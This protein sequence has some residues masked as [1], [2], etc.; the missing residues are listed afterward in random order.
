M[1]EISW[2]EGV[3]DAVR[4][5]IRS[6]EFILKA[7]KNKEGM[8]EAQLFIKNVCKIINQN[9]IYSQSVFISNEFKSFLCRQL[10]KYLI[11]L[12]VFRILPTLVIDD[13]SY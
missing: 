10:L 4:G 13:Y 8:E 1:S 11:Q 6:F 2:L 5:Q 9:S 12:I 3:V 7:Q